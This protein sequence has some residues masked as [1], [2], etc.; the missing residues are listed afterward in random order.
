MALAVSRATR[1]S[2]GHGAA[3][4]AGQ[5]V[6]T[7]IAQLREQADL[8]DEARLPRGAGRRA[9]AWRDLV[10]TA[11]RTQAPVRELLDGLQASGAVRAY[12]SLALANALI[13]HADPD[14]AEA[15]AQALEGQGLL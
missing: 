13:V 8:S 6:T 14:R 10:A 2:P 1:Q 3:R 4:A 15:V 11:E 9:A 12:D 7:F 5:P